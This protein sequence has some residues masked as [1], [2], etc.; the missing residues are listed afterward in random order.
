MNKIIAYSALHYGSPYLG[1]AIQSVIHAVHEYHVL[2]SPDGSHGTKHSYN[3]PSSESEARLYSIALQAAGSKLHWHG[4]AWSHEGQQRDTIYKIAPDADVVLT[5]DYDE[6]WNPLSVQD[7]I[8]QAWHGDARIYRAP[9]V[10]FWRSFKRCVLDDPAFPERIVIPSRQE[11]TFGLLKMKPLAHLGYAIPDELLRYKL[12]IH[13]HKNEM[14]T[15]I[16]WYNERWKVNAQ[17]DCHWT[18][19]DRWYPELID[20]RSHLPALM[21]RHPYWGKDLIE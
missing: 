12:H 3:L 13:G 2:Y 6:I 4:G 9:M 18:M 14:R 20:P 5:L 8:E 19:I 21:M 15:D 16:D 10:H 17:K 7:A 1:Y 11:R